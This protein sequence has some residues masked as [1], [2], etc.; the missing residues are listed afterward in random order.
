MRLRITYWNWP[1]VRSDGTRYFFLSISGIE[2]EVDVERVERSQITGIL[3]GYFERMRWD[4]DWRLSLGFFLN[5]KGG[6][7]RY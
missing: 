6:G 5:K 1:T 4:S 2:E 3:S 7:G